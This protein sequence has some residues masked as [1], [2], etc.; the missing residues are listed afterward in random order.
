MVTGTIAV[1]KGILFSKCNG[2]F[3]GKVVAP[4]APVQ[5]Y[6]R[7]VS[8]GR[9]WQRVAPTSHTYILNGRKAANIRGATVGT[10]TLNR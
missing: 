4:A 5:D 7:T 1:T 10:H 3:S 6:R 9:K 2:H 8:D